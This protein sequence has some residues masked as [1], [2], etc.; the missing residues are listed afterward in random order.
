[1]KKKHVN[2]LVIIIT[3]LILILI[4]V[5]KDHLYGS[6]I[7]WINQHTTIPDL[8]RNLFYETH[9]LIPNF[10]FNLGAGQNIFNFSYYGLMSPIILISYFLPFIK[11]ETFISISSIVIYTL[12]GVLLFEFLT[13]N[14]ASN[15]ISL[16]ATLAFQCMAPITFQFHHHIMF[17]WYLPFL[18]LAL[19]GVDRYLEKNK[20]LLLI[21][22]I[23]LIILTNYYYSIPCLLTIVIYGCY[24]V[25][26]QGSKSFKEFF[27]TCLKASI[28]IIIPILMAS[29]ILLPT[30]ITMFKMGRNSESMIT[31][32]NLILPN[33][34][35]IAYSS[36]GIGLSFLILIAPFGNLCNKKIK[37]EDIFLN[38]T[39]IIIT[40]C[41]IFM[42]FLNGKLY[43]RGKVL[44]PLTIIYILVLVKFLTTLKQNKINMNKLYKII[45]IVTIIFVLSNFHSYY[46]IAFSF[47]VVISIISLMLFRK[48]KRLSIIFIPLIVTLFVSSLGNNF[49]ELYLP[50]NTNEDSQNIE[51][52][53]DKRKDSSFYRTDTLIDSN[54][55]ANRIYKNDYYSTTAYSSTYNR[56]YH[57]FYTSKIGNNIEHRN[58]LNTSG[59]NNYLFNKMLGV[60]YIISSR[61]HNAIY[62]KIASEN[63]TNLYKNK[64]A[65]PL[66]FTT[67]TYGSDKEY[68]SLAF[69]YNVEYLVNNQTT[70]TNSKIKY[71]STIKK[72]SI[73]EKNSYKLNLK[74]DKKINYKLPKPIKNKILIISFDMTYNQSCSEG[75][76]AIKIN[77]IKNKLTCKEWQYHN[78]NNN[79]Q[80]V[81][82]NKKEYTNLNIKLSKGKY[83][84]TNIKVY[85]MDFPTN[86]YQEISNFKIDKSKSEITGTTKE[87]EAS[88]LI[89]SFPYDKG[90]TAYIDNN[91]VK[92]EIVN[93]SFLGF[94]VP[95]GK[96][97]IKIKY[98]SL[99]YQT[100]I[101][102]SFIGLFSMF[103]L[104]LFENNKNNH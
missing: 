33:L 48:Y 9:K 37:V 17:V 82:S 70:E 10:I 81:I 34:K 63:N 52:L 18:I 67:T 41:P 97:Q 21:I 27:I 11:M 87:K 75:D 99:G 31:L 15:K 77:G 14:K 51:K 102:I 79:F 28:R 98:S 42:Y 78:K 84:I 44:I 69:P 65:N 2:Y 13:K 38:V 64:N 46:T 68:N 45:G 29:F 24:K 8:F 19:F 66:A 6:Q 39:L 89:T 95:K 85:T 71:N 58:M 83:H 59:A 80:Y 35:E 40:L 56:Y 72:I 57:D 3:S 62:E 49:S 5:G 101:I 30:A 104:V 26:E 88:Y 94:K 55:N 50:E 91:K 22:S 100:G 20:S 43:I 92:S 74:K 12:T 103:G 93:T 96:H 36:F 76:T 60:K 32:S 7:D 90:F 25:L 61:K 4:L 86:T 47:D 73:G 1:M 53:L 54:R 23:F 16:F